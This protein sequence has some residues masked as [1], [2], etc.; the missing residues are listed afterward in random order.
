[1]RRYNQSLSLFGDVTTSSSSCLATSRRR[2]HERPPNNDTDWLYLR[3]PYISDAIDRKITNIFKDEGF[4][5]RV[6]HRSKSLRQALA[7]GRREN[8]R[9]CTRFNCATAK[10]NLCFRK[11]V[12]Y[13]ITCDQCHDNYVGSTIR[14]LHDRVKEHLTQT[15]SS[16]F[17]HLNACQRNNSNFNITTEVIT[18]DPDTVNLR[19]KEAIHIRKHK[20]QINSR[21]E[22]S[23]LSDLLF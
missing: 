12:V 10:H 22:Y 13:K 19:L 8:I 14:N 15:T 2:R 11:N 20:P 3:T 9:N 21:E 5:I 6:V 18:S 1:V 4:P 16:V 23:E 17:N 7:P